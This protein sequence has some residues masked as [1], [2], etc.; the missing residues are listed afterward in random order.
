MDSDRETPI[1][2]KLIA[3]LDGMSIADAQ[4]ALQAAERELLTSQFVSAEALRST[5]E[6]MQSDFRALQP[7]DQ[8]LPH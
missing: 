5:G 6:K 1:T 4:H 8:T 3:L 2:H 7:E